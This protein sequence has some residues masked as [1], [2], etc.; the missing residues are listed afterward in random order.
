MKS[1][2][3]KTLTKLLLLILFLSIEIEAQ[4][5]N[6]TVVFR[7][8]TLID[9]TSEQPKPNM[10]VIVSGNRITKIGKNV[11][12]PKNAEACA[13]LCS[14]FMEETGP[15]YTAFL[16]EIFAHFQQSEKYKSMDEW[17]RYWLY[18]DYFK[19]LTN[20]LNRVEP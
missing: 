6:S 12:I 17:N 3:Y 11:K 1:Q 18:D 20:F 14:A 13:D 9:M 7:N 4:E 16:H 2:T 5:R 19:V 10:T 15:M 8:V